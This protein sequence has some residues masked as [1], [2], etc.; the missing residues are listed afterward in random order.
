MGW[1]AGLFLA[2]CGAHGAIVQ[3]DL[4][5]RRVVLYRNGVGYFE[6]AG[7]TTK[8]A[9]RF[10]VRRGDVGDFLTSLAVLDETG[11]RVRSV[12]FEAPEARERQEPRPVPL[13][14]H[15]GRLAA[16]MPPDPPAQD[17]NEEEQDEDEEPLDVV[18]R[19][20]RSGMHDL[21][22]A[23]VV[24]TPLWRPTYR[25]VFGPE[26]GLLQAW[27]VVQNTSGEDWTDVRMALTTGAPI[28]F[29]SDLGTPIVPQR[30]LVT[31]RG[32]VVT[33]VPRSHGTLPEPRSA[34][35]RA[36]PAARG[37]VAGGA[38][39][40]PSMDVATEAASPSAPPVAASER[41]AFFDRRA[42]ASS[43]EVAARSEQAPGGVTRYELT[44]T[45][46]VPDGGSTMVA[47]LAH[48]V[49]GE[50]AHLY[51]PEGGV[52]GS[53]RHPFR[54]AR[55]ENRTGAMLERGPVTV[56][57]EGEFV[58]QGV[59]EPLPADASAFVPFAMDR[60]VTV[61]RHVESEE[62]PGRLVAIS[63][64][65]LLIEV[66]RER[67]TR[68]EARNGRDR[69]IRLYVRHGRQSGMKIVE[70]ADPRQLTERAAVLRLQVPPGKEAVLRVRERSRIQRTVALTTEQGARAVELYLEGPA[71]EGPH[72]P[73]LRR[74]LQLRER[75]LE[76]RRRAQ[77]VEQAR[78][79][80]E[81][82]AE[83]IRRNL[84]A[85]RQVERASD[86]RQRLVR[87][88]EEMDRRLADLTRQA[89][90][91]REEER[92]L[93]IQLEE[94]LQQVTLRQTES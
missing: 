91:L 10:R 84:K 54:V 51:A 61:E 74:A 67:I 28:A 94:L 12:S 42:A 8:D 7:H 5:V 60:S 49:P 35:R 2:G 45:V 89:V 44:R 3:S 26:G 78:R 15:D 38:P 43:A 68:Y 82:S 41:Q 69:P 53:A 31:D 30:P 65:R 11:A 19:M 80:A 63:K 57:E 59:L 25:L 9:V 20:E 46:T 64:G 56:F 62:R 34:A 6:R 77:E 52:S 73:I 75:L 71:A 40:A 76:V 1:L 79:D 4:P 66:F 70:P 18:L 32:E 92:L 24:G 39:M 22:V 55:F 86:L 14:L 83:Q 90:S 36:R 81:R 58:G 17:G 33:V 29:R 47:L 85:L 72:A 48:R 21:R 88:L 37:P 87:R 23:Y 13:V 16:V 50:V 93:S 27:A